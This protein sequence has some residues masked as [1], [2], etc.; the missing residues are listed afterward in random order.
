MINQDK[1]KSRMILNSSSRMVARSVPQTYSQAKQSKI[2][3]NFILKPSHLKSLAI[4][5]IEQH[6]K[7]LAKKTI[8]TQ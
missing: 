7:Y 1:F 8:K 6:K 2:F 4:V 3:E 5:L